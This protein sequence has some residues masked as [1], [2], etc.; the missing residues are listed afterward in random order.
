MYVQQANF[1]FGTGMTFANEVM[2]TAVRESLPA[3]TILFEEGESANE[4]EPAS[5]FYVLLE[6]RV[7]IGFGD[8]GHV[9]YVVSHSGE[10]FGWSSLVGREKYSTTGETLGPTTLNVMKRYQIT[11]RKIGPALSGFYLN[12]L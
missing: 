1:F 10:A 9:V 6:G 11:D 2:K 7:R 3:G 12:I 4:G 5:R 8:S